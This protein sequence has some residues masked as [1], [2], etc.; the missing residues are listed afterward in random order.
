MNFDPDPDHEAARRGAATVCKDVLSALPSDPNG[1][2]RGAFAVFDS[3]GLLAGE[4]V[5]RAAIAATELGRAS[6]SLGLVFA[7][8]FGFARATKWLAAE[9]SAPPPACSSLGVLA[10]GSSDTILGEDGGARTLT[11]EAPFVVGGPVATE[12]L[13]VLPK[14]GGPSAARVD[15]GSSG[16]LRMPVVPLLGFDRAPVCTLRFD[17]VRLDRASVLAPADSAAPQISN[18][19]NL[20]RTL[21]AS[22]AVGIGRHAFAL[23]VEHLRSL[24]ERPS[25]STEFSLSDV[26]TELD[27][28]ELSALRAASSIDRGSLQGL[29][30]ANAAMLAARAATRAAQT[31][32]VLA[33]D[34]GYT[35]KLRQCYL[36]ACALAFRDESGDD[37]VDTIAS[38]MLGES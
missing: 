2:F 8:C 15:L 25:Q 35:G 3:R 34:S 12:C 11:G 6:G 27:A 13:V 10:F 37:Q 16:A 33:G 32:L 24:G 1:F 19:S 23:V 5:A 14:K 4:S 30:G 7:S 18:V 38:E 31:A 21:A 29:E 17:A 22:V 36:D 28:A 20:R 26:A 9:I